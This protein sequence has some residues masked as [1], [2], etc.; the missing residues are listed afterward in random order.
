MNAPTGAPARVTSDA[1]PRPCRR[2]FTLIEL[3][4]VIAIIA[5]L[6]G[7]ILPALG[8]ARE[9]GRSVLCLSNLRQ[10]SMGWNAYADENRDVM[11]PHR[12]PNLPGGVNNPA[13]WYD[14]G[15][16]MK[17]RPAW[18]AR[19]GAYVGIWPH[20]EPRTDTGR[21]DYDSRVF[22]CPSVADWT[23]ERNAAYG[24][25]YQFLGNSRQTNGRFHNFPVRRS[26]IMVAS[27]TVIGADSMGTACSFPPEARLP[28]S[29]DGTSEAEL[30]NEALTIDPPRLT[31]Q[32][33]MASSPYRNGADPRHQRRLNVLFTDAHAK[34]M[35]LDALGYRVRPDGT[36]ETFGS[37]GN[38]P[39]NRYFSGTGVDDDPPPLPN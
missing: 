7:I 37:P 1:T 20:H 17:F 19:M 36:Y 34:L 4:V 35:T 24:Y 26:R 12:P 5:L 29:N 16:G 22:V 28:Y 2:A 25:N 14:V 38:M 15:N 6:I 27:D 13:N 39:T 10:L 32:S 30:G 3:L 18:I 11:V 31:P 8:S 21:Q 33:D 9:S 23:D